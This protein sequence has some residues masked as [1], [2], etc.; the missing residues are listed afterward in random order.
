MHIYSIYLF[1]H[2]QNKQLSPIIWTFLKEFI[3]LS[4]IFIVQSDKKWKLVT[5]EIIICCS[6]ECKM[7]II[8]SKLFVEGKICLAKKG[9]VDM[10]IK[11]HIKHNKIRQQEPKG[12]FSHCQKHHLQ[13]LNVELISSQ[14]ILSWQRWN[15]FYQRFMLTWIR[16]VKDHKVGCFLH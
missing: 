10:E 16:Y 14:I 5:K 11:V 9:D 4:A 6:C 15:F 7:N 3:L 8:L 1:G 12:V 13:Y 2:K